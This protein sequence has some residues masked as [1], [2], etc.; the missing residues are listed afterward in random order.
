MM[1]HF[2]DVGDHARSRRLVARLHLD[3]E[4][5]PLAERCAQIVR[6]AREQQRAVAL[7]L[8]QARHHLVH[9]RFSVTI[10]DGPCS[11]SGGGVSPRPMRS[12]VAPRSRNGRAR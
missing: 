11:G 6:N 9:A 8:A 2:L 4:A 12:T 7:D 5:Q 10:S 1:V 3:A